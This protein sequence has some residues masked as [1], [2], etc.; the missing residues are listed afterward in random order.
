M[1]QDMVVRSLSDNDLSTAA[2]RNVGQAPSPYITLNMN[3]PKYVL[4]KMSYRF[5]RG[6]QL[7]ADSS[8]CGWFLSLDLQM[9]RP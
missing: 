9:R 8:A 7:P 1:H 3:N 2:N 4:Q 5:T 6:Y